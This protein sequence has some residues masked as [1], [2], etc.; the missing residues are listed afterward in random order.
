MT[1]IPIEP[2]NIGAILHR[3]GKIDLFTAGNLFP[4]E[5]ETPRADGGTGLILEGDGKGNFTAL[6]IKESGIFA[7]RDVRDVGMLDIGPGNPKV[8]VVANNNSGIQLFLQN[9]KPAN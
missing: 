9:K 2:V 1:I 7:N 8:I 3:L 4:A 5:V 6:S